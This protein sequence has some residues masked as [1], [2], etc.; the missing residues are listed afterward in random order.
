MAR[1]QQKRPGTNRA[2][3][4]TESRKHSTHDKPI[5]AHLHKS[6]T[7]AV[8]AAGRL[9]AQ[10]DAMV[11]LCV[12]I[13][14]TDGEPLTMFFGDEP[15]FNVAGKPPGRGTTTVFDREAQA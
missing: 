1:K 8:N 4:E 12:T 7:K 5:P 13:I 3:P 11:V 2:N 9:N 15:F 6:L 14:T 10:P